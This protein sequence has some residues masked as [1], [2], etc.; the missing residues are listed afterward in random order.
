MVC[1]PPEKVIVPGYFVQRKNRETGGDALVAS[2]RFSVTTRKYKV[3]NKRYKFQAS[4]K[5]FQDH[6]QKSC[7]LLPTLL[8]TDKLCQ[9]GYHGQ[10]PPVSTFI[11]GDSLGFWDKHQSWQRALPWNV[12]QAVATMPVGWEVFVHAALHVNAILAV[13]MGIVDGGTAHGGKRCLPAWLHRRQ[14][15][16]NPSPDSTR[17]TRSG[18]Y[19]IWTCWTLTEELKQRKAKKTS[20]SQCQW[21]YSVLDH[22]LCTRNVGSLILIVRPGLAHSSLVGIEDHRSCTEWIHSCSLSKFSTCYGIYLCIIYI[23]QMCVCVCIFHNQ[24]WVNSV[25]VFK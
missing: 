20:K 1:R 2:S 21:Q 8:V 23:I 12:L 25:R 15:A 16:W 5:S 7:S 13:K 22:G 17:L 24:C 4:T 19:G 3:K 6:Q 9:S 11:L 14:R 18:P 10:S